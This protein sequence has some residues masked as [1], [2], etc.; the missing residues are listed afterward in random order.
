MSTNKGLTVYQSEEFNTYNALNKTFTDN[1]TETNSFEPLKDE[2]ALIKT[3]IQAVKDAVLNKIVDTTNDTADKNALKAKTA[4]HWGNTNKV[5]LGFAIKYLHP[6]LAKLTKQTHSQLEEIT[7]NNFT[8]QI[9][10]IYSTIEPFLLDPK[11]IKYNITKP[12]LDAGLQLAKD[13]QAY[14]GT[15]KH[16]E[17][18]VTVAVEEVEALFLPLKENFTQVSLLIENFAPE[19]ATPNADFYKAV[20]EQLFF[21]HTSVHTI[22]DGNILIKGTKTGIRNAQF[23]NL[24]NGRFVL[25]DLL[26]YFKMEKFQGGQIEFE[27]S[28]PGF[29]TL[30]LIIQIKQ[31]KHIA[32]DY[33]LEPIA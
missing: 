1:P 3:N 26:G 20:K 5:L 8:P 27:I 28:A 6:E 25:T 17:G 2:A 31:G 19:G 13:F 29:K 9:Q 11:F 24:K 33:E 32:V 7:D 18:K 22:I 10:L 14:L 30:K 16:T 21:Y 12:T 23:K 4:F 15:N